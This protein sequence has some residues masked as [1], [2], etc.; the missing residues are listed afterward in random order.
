MHVPRKIPIDDVVLIRKS[1]ALRTLFDVHACE[2]V[3]LEPLELGRLVAGCDPLLRADEVAWCWR[4]CNEIKTFELRST[5]LLHF[6]QHHRIQYS[7]AGFLRIDAEQ[8][9]KGIEAQPKLEDG[10]CQ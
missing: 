3:L 2:A 8:L 1:R 5:G 6:L 9:G 10:S 7:M 4:P